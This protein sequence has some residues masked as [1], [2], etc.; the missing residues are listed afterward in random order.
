MIATKKKA[1]ASGVPKYIIADA[2]DTLNAPAAI[3]TLEATDEMDAVAD[4]ENDEPDTF[5]RVGRFDFTVR[6]TEATPESELRFKNRADALAAWLL[7]KWRR[8]QGG[9]N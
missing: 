2:I 8:E 7:A 9:N 4:L 6:A 1:G 3:G 5:E